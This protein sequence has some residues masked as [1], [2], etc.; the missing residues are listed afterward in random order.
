VQAI[1]LLEMELGKFTREKV[2]KLISMNYI[3]TVYNMQAYQTFRLMPDIS[4]NRHVG[5][6][7]N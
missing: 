6:E 2:R 3:A 5:A 1:D 7:A 4:A